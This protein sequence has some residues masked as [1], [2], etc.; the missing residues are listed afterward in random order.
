MRGGETRCEHHARVL[1][2]RYFR[3]TRSKEIELSKISVRSVVLPSGCGNCKPI[4]KCRYCC[5]R[6]EAL[7]CLGL[8]CGQHT[9]NRGVG[10]LP[11]CPRVAFFARL[12]DARRRRR[13]MTRALVRPQTVGDRVITES[14]QQRRRDLRGELVHSTALLY[15]DMVR[16]AS[17]IPYGIVDNTS[18]SEPPE[19]PWRSKLDLTPQTNCLQPHSHTTHQEPGG[20]IAPPRHGLRL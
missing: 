19:V 10:A 15:Q 3:G 17:H 13:H 7:R 18:A 4:Q 5:K 12:W 20:P 14:T 9:P 6:A 1:L 16:W 2:R 11:D 8:K